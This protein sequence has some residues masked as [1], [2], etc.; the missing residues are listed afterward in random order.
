MILL[1]QFRQC[2]LRR[3]GK[4]DHRGNF[5]VPQLL[6]RLVIVEISLLHVDLQRI[7]Y[8]LRADLSLA[9]FVAESFGDFLMAWLGDL[10]MDD[11]PPL[12]A[13][14]HVRAR[15]TAPLELWPDPSLFRSPQPRHKVRVTT[16]GRG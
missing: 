7:E 5:T 16:T 9:V 11:W 13:H 2:G 6:D 4:N 15:A 3:S 12:A 10:S 1:S 14:W 8:E